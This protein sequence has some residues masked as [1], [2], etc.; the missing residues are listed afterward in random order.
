[1]TG[2]MRCAGVTS[3]GWLDRRMCTPRIRENDRSVIDLPEERCAVGEGYRVWM[4]DVM[5]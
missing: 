4:R 2:E 1:V 5:G 3:G